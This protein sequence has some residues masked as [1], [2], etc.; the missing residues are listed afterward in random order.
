MHSSSGRDKRADRRTNAIGND[1]SEV[2]GNRIANREDG[3]EYTG[4]IN[5]GDQH[6]TGPRIEP[7]KQAES[8]RRKFKRSFRYPPG[9]NVDSN[10]VDNHSRQC[11]VGCRTEKFHFEEWKTCYSQYLETLYSEFSKFA[12]TYKVNYESFVVF[13]YQHSSGYISPYA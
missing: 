12:K 7:P 13:V 8:T 3:K 6:I 11:T 9:T 1:G 5:K 4:L 2:P 10:W